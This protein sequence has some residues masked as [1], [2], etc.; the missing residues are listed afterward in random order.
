MDNFG[1]HANEE[2]RRKSTWKVDVEK[3]GREKEREKP[4]KKLNWHANEVLV[5][6]SEHFSP[7]DWWVGNR[8]KETSSNQ[9]FLL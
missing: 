8:S 4:E 5:H 3:K 2:G 6:L 1:G 7:T 9:P